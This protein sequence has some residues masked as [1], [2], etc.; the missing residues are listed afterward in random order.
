MSSTVEIYPMPVSTVS[1]V[2]IIMNGDKERA[3]HNATR[4]RQ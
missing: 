2:G 1:M 3:N 4:T